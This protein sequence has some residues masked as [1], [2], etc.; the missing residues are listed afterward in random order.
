MKGFVW[1]L[2]VA[3]SVFTEIVAA[4]Y[5]VPEANERNVARLG[6]CSNSSV[7]RRDNSDRHCSWIING[8]KDVTDGSRNCFSTA[9][10]VTKPSRLTV[11]LKH[12]YYIHKVVIYGRSNDLD[13]MPQIQVFFD[14]IP[15]YNVSEKRN[16]TIWKIP[17]NSR[18]FAKNVLLHK[19][20]TATYRDI[21]L[22]EVEIYTC[23]EGFFWSTLTDRVGA[24]RCK[25]W[26]WLCL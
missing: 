15:V 6:T 23:N 21:S 14:G 26:Q 1:R 24:K 4:Q 9:D 13:R 3:L 16:V 20:N 11:I 18:Q 5:D 17:E 19:D 22:C 8:N 12:R 7:S 25:E 2:V 10:E